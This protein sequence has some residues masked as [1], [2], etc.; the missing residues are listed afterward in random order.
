MEFLQLLS[1]FKSIANTFIKDSEGNIPTP[2]AVLKFAHWL[3]GAKECNYNNKGT[4]HGRF[5]TLE[6]V[7]KPQTFAFL[8][9]CKKGRTFLILPTERQ[10]ITYPI[11][12]LNHNLFFMTFQWSQHLTFPPLLISK[13]P[14]API[15]WWKLFRLKSQADDLTAS[16]TSAAGFSWDYPNFPP[17]G[18]ASW[19]SDTGHAGHLSHA[20]GLWNFTQGHQKWLDWRENVHLFLKDGLEWNWLKRHLDCSWLRRMFDLINKYG[21]IVCWNNEVVWLDAVLWIDELQLQSSGSGHYINFRIGSRRVRIWSDKRK[22]GL[23]Y[24]FA[25]ACIVECICN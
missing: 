4:A 3:H 7:L 24:D 1:V 2:W 20:K 13:W 5:I 11:T 14:F 18:K 10:S 19:A 25:V 12:S 15:V 22:D 21:M 16:A 23:S 9:N 8:L 6:V 17:I